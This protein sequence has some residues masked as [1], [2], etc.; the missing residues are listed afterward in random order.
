VSDNLITRTRKR[1][2]GTPYHHA[3][4]WAE[5]VKRKAARLRCH[6]ATVGGRWPG[7][8]VFLPQDRL[9]EIYIEMGSRNFNAQMLMNPTPSDTALFQLKYIQNNFW[10][11]VATGLNIY[12][13]VDPNNLK[14]DM[15]ENR[16]RANKA[17]YCSMWVLGLGADRGYYTLQMERDKFLKNQRIDK[18]FEL[19]DEWNPICTFYFSGGENSDVDDIRD[20]QRR[21]NFRFPIEAVPNSTN[22]HVLIPELEGVFSTRKFWLP[23]KQIRTDWQGN[24]VDLVQQFIYDE[25]VTYPFGA[26]DDS[27]DALSMI[28]HPKVRTELRFPT[29]GESTDR[30]PGSREERDDGRYEEYDVLGS[31]L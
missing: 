25:F 11:P 28:K 2:K 12:L 4:L 21:E 22:K 30:N 6:P 15:L 19:V 3:G 31:G 18:V 10:K 27:L 14:T 7:K 29:R 5:I 13:F 9:E 23:E 24:K 1:Y 16:K 20:R 26:H 17:D 8:S